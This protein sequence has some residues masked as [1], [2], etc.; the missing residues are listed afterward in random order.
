MSGTEKANFH[1]LKL[2]YLELDR[3]PTASMPVA[4]ALTAF[5]SSGIGK[6]RKSK[7]AMCCSFAPFWEL[8][9]RS[10]PVVAPQHVA[11]GFEQRF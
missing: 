5:C 1:M 4:R 7:F 10:H 2:S 11:H 6:I 8:A 3:D 9:C